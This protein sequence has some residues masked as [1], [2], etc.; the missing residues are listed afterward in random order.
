M[1][2]VRIDEIALSGD[3]AHWAALGFT[4][5]DGAMRLGAVTVR[6]LAHPTARG[7]LGWSL[8]GA[9]GTEL[10]GLPTTLSTRPAPAG[11][12]GEHANGVS[13]ID[14]IVVISPDLDRTVG[15]L[16]AA[17]LSLRRIREEP[18]P[19]G[20][21]R[22]AFFRLGEVILEVVQEPEEALARGGGSGRPAR[23]WGLALLAEDIERAAT[24]LAPNISPIRAAVQPGR[25][26]ATISR[27]AGLSVPVV[28]MSPG[29]GGGG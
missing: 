24:A 23:F 1:T 4:V 3:P 6:F 8:G 5:A 29:E 20:A 18:T 28:L 25:R 13:A 7:M 12:P 11:D 26:I 22:Q 2:A 10:D 9:A 16:Q 17:G 19:A 15:A 14:H 27:A 21:P